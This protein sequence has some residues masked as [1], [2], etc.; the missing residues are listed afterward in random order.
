MVYDSITQHPTLT[1]L[2]K[3]LDTNNGREKLLRTLQYLT[4]LL[5]YYFLRSG[6]DITTYQLSKRIQSL[7]TLSRKP[8]RALKPLTHLKKLSITVDDELTDPYLK[9]FEALRQFGYSLYFSFDSIQWL[10]LLGLLS[11]KS[12]LVRKIDQYCYSFWLV[13]LIGGIL[14]NLRQLRITNVKSKEIAAANAKAKATTTADDLVKNIL[15]SVVALSG[16]KLIKADEGL[17]ASA[18]I[19]TSVLGVQD[20]WRSTK[21]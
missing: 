9:N 18:G 16:L 12:K 19:I 5:S 4:R 8:L 13:A 14:N 3:F 11:S 7:L 21:I 10:K 15:D 20:L 1:K 2:I 17:V 6:Y